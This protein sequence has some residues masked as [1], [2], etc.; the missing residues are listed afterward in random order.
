M[1]PYY[2]I[3]VL[4]I[5]NGSYVVAEPIAH[6]VKA[7]GIVYLKRLGMVTFSEKAEV[8]GGIYNGDAI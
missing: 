1:I 5:A 7:E 2:F 4:A 3:I 6:I 8:G